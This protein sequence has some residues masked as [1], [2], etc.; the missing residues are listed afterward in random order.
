MKTAI[1]LPFALGASVFLFGPA[2]AQQ[3]SKPVV[4]KCQSVNN[5]F[6]MTLKIQGNN[7]FLNDRLTVSKFNDVSITFIHPSMP[8]YFHV[9]DRET[10]KLTVYNKDKTFNSAYN[11]QIVGSTMF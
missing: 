11:C 10:G 8:E 5:S 4:L 1:F 2:E 7:L 3:P 9:L 6:F